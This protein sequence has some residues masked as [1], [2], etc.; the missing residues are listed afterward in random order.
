MYVAADVYRLP[1]VPGLFDAA[2]MIRVLH[3]MS[4]PQL[5]LN[6]VR[7]CLLPGATFILEYAN[8][9]NFKAI[10]R[11]WLKKQDWS[12]FSQEPVEFIPLNYDFHPE[13]VRR[14][15]Q[16][17]QFRIE[18]LLTVSHFRVDFLK[19]VVPAGLLVWLDSLAQWTGDWWQLTPSV[20]VRNRA[21][22]DTP[23]AEEGSFFRCPE[24]KQPL[25]APE[26]DVFSCECGLRWG[27][28]DGIYNFKDPLS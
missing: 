13:A 20:F 27:I 24:C 6:Q 22:G 8:K 4:E 18:R 3:H 11:Y 15:L 25:T 23:T 14:W 5:A 1:F 7:E 17:E 2:T 28:E 10:L 16:A 12:P 26:G 9:Q 21:V 19:R